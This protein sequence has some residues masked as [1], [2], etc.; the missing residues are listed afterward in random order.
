[1]LISGVES[2]SFQLVSTAFRSWFSTRYP[3]SLAIR[4]TAR[5]SAFQA[6]LAD[7]ASPEGVGSIA[8]QV[9]S[10]QEAYENTENSRKRPRVSTSGTD[11]QSGKRST[12][13]LDRQN[14]KSRCRAC[15]RQ[16]DISKCWL[17]IEAIRPLEWVPTQN[18]VAD[19]E[20]RMKQD[21]SFANLVEKAREEYQ[22]QA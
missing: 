6:S 3:S 7:A 21:K 15:G 11:Q 19:F 18:R 17:A 5:G 9:A 10:S 16:H 2:L 4:Q 22:D 1:M 12:P 8:N 20:R 14:R 13:V